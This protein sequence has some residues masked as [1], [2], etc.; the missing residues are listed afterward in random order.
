MSSYLY[1]SLVS[2]FCKNCDNNSNSEQLRACI[3]TEN[4][5]DQLSINELFDYAVSDDAGK[6]R[7]INNYRR[8]A[9]K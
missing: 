8:N 6:Q 2:V 7:I 3:E 5:I 4:V 1:K 9:N